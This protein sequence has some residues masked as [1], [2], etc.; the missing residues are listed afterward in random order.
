MPEPWMWY[1]SLNYTAPYQS[2]YH[3]H[4]AWQLTGSMEGVFRFRIRKENRT[5]LL[6]PGHWALFSPELVHD[7]G[8]DSPHSRALQIF[9]RRFPSDLFPELASRFNLKRG[10]SR[11][12]YV[13]PELFRNIAAR[14]LTLAGNDKELGQSW[15]SLLG[16]EFVLSA[17]SSLPSEPEDSGKMD[18]AMERVLEYMEAHY[19]E[20]L[21]L[22]D[23]ARVAGLSVSRFCAVFKKTSGVSPMEYFNNIRLGCAQYLLLNGLSVSEVTQLSGFSSPQYFCKFFRKSTG[24]TPGEFRSAPFG[25]KP[26]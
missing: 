7:A 18:P 15:R 13:E 6:P 5:I 3:R 4:S 16:M 1:E 19:G 9:F 11:T 14:F 17:L 21:G 25:H 24:I 2:A 12:G 8:S 20:T 10:I 22:G 23:F 26:A